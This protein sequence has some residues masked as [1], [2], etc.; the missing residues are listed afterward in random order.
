MDTRGTTYPDNQPGPIPERECREKD[1]PTGKCITTTRKGYC[2]N[3]RTARSN[4]ESSGQAYKRATRSYYKRKELFEWTQHNYELYRDFDI[5]VDSELIAMS[6]SLTANVKTYSLL[7]Q[8][9]YANL[10]KVVAAIADLKTKVGAL[11]EAGHNLDKYR[12][13]QANATQWCLLT[14]KNDGN[15]RPEPEPNRHRPEP[16]HHQHRPETCKE[17]DKVYDELIHF[18][19][20]VLI[21]DINS[22]MQSA[23]DTAGIQTFTNVDG[24]T[25][26]QTN[27]TTATTTLVTKIQAV[28]AT[29]RKDLD[30]CQTELATAVSNCTT[31]GVN[32]YG[33]ISISNGEHCTV[34]FLCCPDCSCV[35][36]ERSDVLE[37]HLEKCECCICNI[38]E[39]IRST[40]HHINPGPKPG[41]P[42]DR[43]C[44]CG[45]QS[46]TKPPIN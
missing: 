29:R 20:K 41:G 12:N 2:T 24:L 17:V 3:L 8:T 19:K 11:D 36:P 32:K 26:L 13:D 42:E 44:G 21:P 16:E 33:A 9:L 39:K 40:Y 35:F 1:T 22:L 18:T 23:S 38:G 37:P 14:G 28:A 34:Q 25:A 10:K 4:Q 5:C 46:P 7:S 6:T 15:C 30:G 31:A 45:G 43:D 27:F